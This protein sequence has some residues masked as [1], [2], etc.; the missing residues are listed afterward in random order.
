MPRVAREKSSSGIYHIILRGINRQLIFNDE[1]DH[2]RLLYTLNNCRDESGYK[3]Y[4]Y[5]LMGNHLHLLARE[6]HEDLGITMRRIGASYVYWYNHKYERCGHLFQDRYKSETVED[7]S[8]LL[9]V[10]RYIH[11]NPIKA[12]ITNDVSLYRWSSYQEYTVKPKIIEPDYILN[13]FSNDREKAQSQFKAF[14]KK[15]SDRDCLDI[16]EVKKIKD[17]EAVIIIKEISGLSDIS[18]IKEL[19]KGDRD[20]MIRELKTKGLSM[21]QIARLT[22]IVRSAVIRA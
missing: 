15:T 16:D 12:G 17:K 22:G 6:G 7:D 20:T 9:T 2:E 4:A 3:I 5:C 18:K 19:S 11:H 10:V 13:V 14:H 21:R 8:Y 1:E